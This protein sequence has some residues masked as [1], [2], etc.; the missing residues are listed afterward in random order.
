MTQYNIYF[1]TI[2]K[3]LG[4][5]YQFTRNCKNEQEAADIA[6]NGA[7]SM[8]YKYEGKF[9]IP[10]FSQINRE[11]QITGIDIEKLYQEHINDICRYYAI[12]T[13]VDSISNRKLKF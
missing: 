8:Y 6:K 9:G 10:S 11:S 13:Q 7:T 2:G 4:C 12:P 1:G 3:T 5:K